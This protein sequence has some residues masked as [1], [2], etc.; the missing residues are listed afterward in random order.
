MI[1]PSSLQTTRYKEMKDYRLQI[2]QLRIFRSHCLQ[3]L[4][5]DP[6]M[7]CRICSPPLISPNSSMSLQVLKPHAS[8]ALPSETD[9]T[10]LPNGF[11]DKSKK[12]YLFTSI[13]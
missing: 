2:R 1:R 5:P 10:V 13:F 9:R 8:A 12:G 3:R 6:V 7:P 4:Q 11:D